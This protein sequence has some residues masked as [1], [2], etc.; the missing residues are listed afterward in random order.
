[1]F[2]K[3]FIW[4]GFLFLTLAVS[5]C[6]YDVEEELYGPPTQC[7]TSF[8]PSYSSHVA[9]L[10]ESKCLV[11]HSAASQL[12]GINLEGYAAVSNYISNG[13]LL[14]SIAH[15]PGFSPMPKGLPKLDACDILTV[16]RWIQGG[17]L[18]N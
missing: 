17:A 7:D 10:V 13:R 3:L 9:P 2:N 15:S 1:M 6:Y 4:G 5:A 16:E 11:C 14:G 12:G 18:N 8:T